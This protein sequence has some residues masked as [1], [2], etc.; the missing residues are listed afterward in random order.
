MKKV[1]RINKHNESQYN[2]INFENLFCDKIEYEKAAKILEKIKI[3]IHIGEKEFNYKEILY[4]NNYDKLENNLEFRDL[5]GLKA[6]YDLIDD[7]D[8]KIQN[9]K[10]IIKETYKLV[11]QNYKRFA[12][13]IEEVEEYIKK[14]DIKFNPEITLELERDKNK[15]KNKGQEKD[16]YYINCISSFKNQITNKITDT[17]SLKYKDENILVNSIK[18]KI[19]GFNSL[20]NELINDYYIGEDPFYIDIEDNQISGF[21]YENN[22]KIND[23]IEENSN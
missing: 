15:E 21:L 8:K 20:I 14:A 18:G 11:Y 2:I 6:D 3:T 12:I 19:E 10:K 9:K 1:K 17:T 22:D 13:F 5:L 23:N 7:Y 4:G 16:I